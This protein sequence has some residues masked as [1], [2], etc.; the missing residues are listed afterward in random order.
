MFTQCPKCQ[1][2]FEFEDIELN[3][4][5]GLVRC[6]ECHEVFDALENEIEDEAPLP[7]GDDN[8]SFTETGVG[9]LLLPAEKA[10][11]PDASDDA[12]YV[13]KGDEDAWITVG[14]PLNQD[15]SNTPTSNDEPRRYDD[16]TPFEEDD[17]DEARHFA[18]TQVHEPAE[19]KFEVIDGQQ[20]D[21]N[22]AQ[23]NSELAT[24]TNEPGPTEPAS[25]DDWEDLLNEIE[26]LPDTAND[27]SDEGSGTNE[28][29][30]PEL[31]LD[32]NEENNEENNEEIIEDSPQE[33]E[34]EDLDPVIDP[35]SFVDSA[36]DVDADSLSDI[37]LSEETDADDDFFEGLSEALNE[38][39]SPDELNDEDADQEEAVDS[40][41]IFVR[42]DELP[43]DDAPPTSIDDSGI[44]VVEGAVAE[45]DDEPESADII[46]EPP[47]PAELNAFETAIGLAPDIK[48][49]KAKPGALAYLAV[50]ALLALC[51]AQLIH[52]Y[53]GQLA[54]LPALNPL[55]TKVYGEQLN[56][57][58]DINA[59]CYEAH[60]VVASNEQMQII[61]ELRN[62]SSRP[63]PYPL[64]HVSLT[65]RFDRGDGN[66]NLGHLLLDADQYLDAGT[67]RERV[68]AG[69]QFRAIAEVADPGPEVSGYDLELCYRDGDNRLVCNGGC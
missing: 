19:V 66:Q 52:Q 53:K 56:P 43:D 9:W 27:A 46:I 11:D 26:T 4:A 28:S 13:A 1:T 64:I 65:G 3:R 35:E 7:D 41:G 54:T 61:A 44:I 45:H 38:G 48:P 10:V 21:K 12:R 36:G 39:T 51:A 40:S 42:E 34:Q 68:G 57:A 18:E 20:S 23:A 49:K 15:A 16:D 69:V 33:K 8:E 59:L 63:Q 24:D 37:L 29:T 67:P 31:A 6:G 60:D 30:P 17:Q 32:D 2:L 22:D 47:S 55:L 25:D 14:K 50:F 62:K 58:W 5:E